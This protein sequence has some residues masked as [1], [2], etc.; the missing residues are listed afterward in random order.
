MNPLPVLSPEKTVR[1]SSGTHVTV[2]EM[3][4]PKARLF[5]GTFGALGNRLGDAIRPA[6]GAA[7]LA[8]VGASILTQLPA[9][10]AD[11]AALSEQLVNGCV[12]EIAA[13]R[14]Q[15]EEL[16]ASD[17]MRLLDASLEVTFNEDIV[18]LGNSVA[19]RVARV[20]GPATPPT[21][22]SPDASTPSS[23]AVGPTGT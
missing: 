3:A 23:P 20:M 21:N 18:R 10:I 13:G 22:S 5:L 7:T 6:A 4:W 1:L 12:P 19:G 11:S 15:V 8:A 9:L 17:F 2:R 16:P 14:V